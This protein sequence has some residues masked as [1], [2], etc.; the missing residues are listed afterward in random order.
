MKTVSEVNSK[1][2]VVF[3]GLLDEG[4]STLEIGLIGHIIDS[5]ASGFMSST[6][7]KLSKEVEALSSIET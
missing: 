1:A 5:R 2:A 3:R 6:L 4:W 7:E